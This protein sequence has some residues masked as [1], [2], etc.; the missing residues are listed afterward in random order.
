MDHEMIGFTDYLVRIGVVFHKKTESRRHITFIHLSEVKAV[1][2]SRY[3]Q[4]H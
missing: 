1:V 4:P 3:H 2:T